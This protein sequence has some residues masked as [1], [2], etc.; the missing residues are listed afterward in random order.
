[1]LND[2][3]RDTYAKSHSYFFDDNHCNVITEE[4]INEI[5]KL[6]RLMKSVVRVCLHSSPQDDL[7]NMIIA[8]PKGWYV[9]PHANLRK[10]KSYHILKGEMLMVGFDQDKKELFRFLLNDKNPIC[11]I[12]KGVYLFLWPVS[13]ICIF[14]EVTIGPFERSKDTYFAEWAPVSHDKN[15]LKFFINSIIKDKYD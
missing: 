4:I 1:M 14:E 3:K 12:K 13:D 7:H 11:R 6:C 10:S 5:D 9:R 15:G 2:L 8:H